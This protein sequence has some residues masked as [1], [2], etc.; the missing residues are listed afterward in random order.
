[1][2]QSL[3]KRNQFPALLS[4]LLWLEYTMPA[5]LV[6][7][8]RLEAIVV[9]EKWFQDPVGQAESLAR[10]AGATAS[11]GALAEIVQRVVAPGLNHNPA[12]AGD[13]ELACSRLLYEALQTG[14]VERGAAILAE[15]RRAIRLGMTR[16]RPIPHSARLKSQIFWVSEG[17][18]NF[19]ELASAYELTEEGSARRLVRLPIPRGLGRNP[20]L[21]LDPADVPG[22]LQ[23]FGIRLLDKIGKVIWEW[24][25]SPISLL[26]MVSRDIEVL[27]GVSSPG[28]LLYMPTPDPIILL[29]V[30][31][32]LDRLSGTGGTLELDF[33]WRGTLTSTWTDGCA[34]ESAQETT[35][36]VMLWI[37]EP[38]DCVPHEPVCRIRGWFASSDLAIAGQLE[39][40]IG[41]A[42][43]P[44]QAEERPD[45]AERYPGLWE[46]GFFF[47]FDLSRYSSAIRSGEFVLTALVPK[48]PAMKLRFSVALDVVAGGGRGA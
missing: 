25:R 29:P 17:N 36:D 22:I 20:H 16:R 13:Y 46:T 47:D 10:V 39:L 14:D 43:V 7:G 12:P 2:A 9:Y 3:K 38:V 32:E 42:L 27:E 15:E 26:T 41:D 37:D 30:S 48:T 45:V 5:V 24:D 23:I 31:K 1:V 19:G 11:A 34:S 40:R 6:A 8:Q 28:V 4:E 18:A 35:G 33:A 21:R 44:W